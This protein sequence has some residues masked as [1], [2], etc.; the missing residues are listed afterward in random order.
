MEATSRPRS[1]KTSTRRKSLFPAEDSKENDDLGVIK[2]LEDDLNFKYDRVNLL[3]ESNR[4]F[5]TYGSPKSNEI[6]SADE[7]SPLAVSPFKN[8]YDSSLKRDRS[9]AIS[10]RSRYLVSSIKATFNEKQKKVDGEQMKSREKQLNFDG[11]RAK[12]DSKGAKSHR[13]TEEKTKLDA[14]VGKF[15]QENDKYS[16]RT[17]NLA[18]KTKLRETISNSFSKKFKCYDE[19]NSYLKESGLS[20]NILVSD[21][22]LNL[23]EIDS[24]LNMTNSS[25][26]SCKTPNDS[27]ILNRSSILESPTMKSPSEKL[28]TPHDTST[29]NALL[30]KLIRK[31]ESHSEAKLTTSDKGESGTKCKVRTALFPDNEIVLS[32]KSFYPKNKEQSHLNRNLLRVNACNRNKKNGSYLC[33]RRGKKKN[34]GVINAGVSHGIKKPRKKKLSKTQILNAAL[35]IIENSPLNSFLESRENT[36]LE[37]FDGSREK[38]LKNQILNACLGYKENIRFYDL[39]NDDFSSEEEFLT[40]EFDI[41]SGRDLNEPKR[42]ESDYEV[43]SSGIKRNRSP[44]P[45]NNKKFFKSSRMKG[46]FTINKNIKLEVEKGKVSLVEKDNK[47]RHLKKNFDIKMK[48]GD[49]YK[50]TRSAINIDQILNTLDEPK[51]N[52]HFNGFSNISEENKMDVSNGSEISNLNVFNSNEIDNSNI[53]DVR[54]TYIKSESLSF[55]ETNTRNVSNA[56]LSPTSQMCNMTSGLVIESPKKCVLNINSLLCDTSDRPKNVFNKMAFSKF[57]DNFTRTYNTAKYNESLAT[58]LL[59]GTLNGTENVFNRSTTLNEPHINNLLCDTSDQTENIFNKSATI[60]ETSMFNG[61]MNLDKTATNETENVSKTTTFNESP[62]SADTMEE[63]KL[64]P[65]FYPNARVQK[66]QTNTKKDTPKKKLKP[67]P[68][69]QYLLDAGQKKF[70]VTQCS[71]CSIVYHIGDPSEEL[72]H[73]NYHNASNVFKFHVSFIICKVDFSHIF[74]TFRVGNTKM[75]WETTQMAESSGYFLRTL[76][77]GGRKLEI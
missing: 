56:I 6:L 72:M 62:S 75:S 51:E 43:K 10:E 52:L 1:G 70:G 67:L 20:P 34:Y 13:D 4:R 17:E 22:P 71:Q 46:V 63:K 50:S 64:F 18:Q 65:I 28:K 24:H 2:P 37:N 31:S 40:K 53:S 61:S 58:T 30:P 16:K 73:S 76:K 27:P 7:L 44:S 36:N 39:E 49:C 25:H 35:K 3:Q 14:Q 12:F 55:N 47:K 45:D 32:T 60:D 42:D 38:K 29:T 9:S 69:D 15:D 26:N 57:D 77:F 21:S 41:T 54:S 8:V 48:I 5:V 19:L 59:Y 74:E 66:T 23:T 11:D 68:N 33:N